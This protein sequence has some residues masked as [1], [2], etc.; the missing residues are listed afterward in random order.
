MDIRE[1]IAQLMARMHAVPQYPA[2]GAT[3]F[4]DLER[5]E[6]QRAY[7]GRE[8]LER[9]IGGR[10]AN[11]YL[12]YNLL[13][14]SRGPLDPDVPLI[15][16]SGALTGDMP[17]AT[18]GNFTSRSPDSD[19]ILDSNA[20]DYFPAFVKRAGFDHIVLYGRAPS[21]SLLTLRTHA[22]GAG[23]VGTMVEFVDAAPYVGLDNLD[24]AAAIER[25]FECQERKDMAM[26]RI[27][28]AGENLVLCS[29]IMGGIK[30]IW[31]RGGAGAKMGALGLKAMV[32]LGEPDDAEY[33]SQLKAQNKVIGKKITSTSVIRNALK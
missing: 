31:A 9:F 4:V 32:V 20:G 26:A 25:D 18:R 10:G 23:A 5:R 7:L 15:F 28:S 17:S 29:G 11:M 30:S 8:V 16:G 21:W 22:G 19:A 2:Q 24:M 1:R 12:L 14:E 27:T 6:T 13:D 3:L 33:Q